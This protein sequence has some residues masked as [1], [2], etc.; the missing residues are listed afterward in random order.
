[1]KSPPMVFTRIVDLPA[2]ALREALHSQ[3]TWVRLPGRI[4]G[5]GVQME[6]LI[7]PW[8]SPNQTLLELVPRTPARPSRRYFRAGHA[9]LDRLVSAG[10]TT[11][12]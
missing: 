10:Q 2:A 5:R 12:D 4:A 11:R 8:T 6:L 3:T 7:S 1:M 9:V